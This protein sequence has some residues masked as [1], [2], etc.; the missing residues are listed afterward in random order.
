M[1]IATNRYIVTVAKCMRV[2][3]E[4]VA[5]SRW[6]Y[7]AIAPKFWIKKD[8]GVREINREHHRVSPCVLNDR[9]SATKSIQVK[10][11][12]VGRKYNQLIRTFVLISK[13]HATKILVNKP[14]SHLDLIDKQ[15]KRIP[16]SLYS[17]SHKSHTG[18]VI[19][20]SPQYFVHHVGRSRCTR[21]LGV[22]QQD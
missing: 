19:E 3:G 10:L 1:K 21:Y 18:V 11:N 16:T 4:F 8:P 5:N 13:L 17:P 12:C 20:F 2:R 15:E 22:R 7:A 6:S 9:S 14:V